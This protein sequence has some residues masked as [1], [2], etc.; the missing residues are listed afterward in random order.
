ML[1]HA[2]E[3]CNSDHN[4]HYNDE[5]ELDYKTIERHY[6]NDLYPAPT[7]SFLQRWLREVHGIYVH[8]ITDVTLSWIYIVQS[9]HPQA[10]YVGKTIQSKNVYSTFEEALEAGLL[11]ALKLI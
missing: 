7:Q 4:D 9:G 3:D 1:K 10:S 6:K 8:I 2:S 11:E 5:E